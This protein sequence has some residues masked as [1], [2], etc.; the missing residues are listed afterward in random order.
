MKIVDFE[1]HPSEL[2]RWRSRDYSLA[3]TLEAFNNQAKA[4]DVFR[5]LNRPCPDGVSDETLIDCRRILP[6]LESIAVIEKALGRDDLQML[7]NFEV[8]CWDECHLVERGVSKKDIPLY[9]RAEVAEYFKAD[10]MLTVN[11]LHRDLR[12]DRE[13]AHR[14][15]RD[16]P[17]QYKPDGKVV[18]YSSQ[19]VAFKLQEGGHSSVHVDKWLCQ[20]SELQA[21][22][23]IDIQS[24]FQQQAA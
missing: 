19:T 16:L 23:P 8:E 3:D 13:T 6:K 11:A 1:P 2:K 15:T 20:N 24:Y 22:P 4:V 9:Y 18:H 17:G 21:V 14:Y 5:Y 7:I 10:V 12:I